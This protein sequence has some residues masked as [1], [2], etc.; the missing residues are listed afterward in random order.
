M[1]G[2]TIDKMKLTNILLRVGLAFSF[3]F[4]AISSFQDPSSWVGFLP[5]FVSRIVEP[6]LF[7]KL[8]SFVEVFVGLWLLSG[9]YVVYA[10]YIS[11]LMLLGIIVFNLPLMQILFR[12]VSILFISLALIALNA[13]REN[14]V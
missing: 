6:F 1:Q 4:A 11:A 5:G 13:E 3:L 14:N 9:R 2:L 10:A 12:D 8:F 7:L